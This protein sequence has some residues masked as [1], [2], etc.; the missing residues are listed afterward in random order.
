MNAKEITSRA[1]N[2]SDTSN[3]SWCIYV[4][5]SDT[6]GL[7]LYP[8][9]RMRDEAARL[10]GEAARF[11]VGPTVKNINI[12]M[13]M[14]S[15][16]DRPHMWKLRGFADVSMLYGYVTE[17][18]TEGVNDDDLY[19]DL[20]VRLDDLGMTVTDLSQGMNVGMTTDGQ[21]V[22]F[23]FDPMFYHHVDSMSEIV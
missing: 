10:Q 13:P 12:E 15:S 16:W 11:G 19:K 22:M 7:K 1:S 6:E 20:I 21:A 9:K 14:L 3:G 8:D 18:V 17:I 23:D 4:P 5:L 2:S